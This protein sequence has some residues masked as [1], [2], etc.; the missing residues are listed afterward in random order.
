METSLY[1]SDSVFSEGTR[2]IIWHAEQLPK[3][4]ESSIV[5][6]LDQKTWKFVV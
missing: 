5:Y 4:A 6:V 1:Y 3:G 2:F